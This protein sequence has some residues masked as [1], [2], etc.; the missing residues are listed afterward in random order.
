MI[1]RVL[2]GSDA[3]TRSVAQGGA[4]R[5]PWPD[6]LEGLTVMMRRIPGR[7]RSGVLTRPFV[8]QLPPTDDFTVSSAFA[9]ADAE[10]RS[11]GTYS[12]PGAMGLRAV[13]F[14]GLFLNYD[15]WGW[16]RD[17]GSVPPEPVDAVRSVEAV[18]RAG[19]PFTLIAFRAGAQFTDGQP[20]HELTELMMPATLRSFDRT[21]RAGEP[22][23][24]Y[25]TAQFVEFREMRLVS[26]SLK[27]AKGTSSSPHLPTSL[28]IATLPAKRDS[29]VELGR[30]YYG[31][32]SAWRV[33]LDANKWMRGHASASDSLPKTLPK[34]LLK[35]HPRV[36]IPRVMVEI[37][38]SDPN[39]SQAEFPDTVEW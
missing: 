2:S 4:V 21:Q 34:S 8:F 7:T 15:Y 13:T 5:P 23:A 39:A 22:D 12:R 6:P 1:D 20:P 28:T 3:T 30:Y 29:L 33:I 19:T 27:A 26:R 32:A 9:W 18:M 31:S 38:H 16:A 14:S 11:A 10:T 24:R 25:F 17:A 35:K 36:L 37:E